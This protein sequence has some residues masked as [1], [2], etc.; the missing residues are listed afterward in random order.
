MRE[1]IET[2]RYFMP[3]TEWLSVADVSEC[4]GV[5]VET[6]RRYI[7]SHGIHLKVKKVHK[8]YLVHNESVA[9]FKQIRELYSDSKNVEEVE[10]ILSS[11]GVPMTVTIENDDDEPMTVSMADELRE[12]K[13]ALI[14]QQQ[15]N[16]DLLEEL[17][18]QKN[19]IENSIEKRDQRLIE[20]LRVIKNE[21]HEA[22][23]EIA[24]RKKKS[25]IF[26]RI[27]NKN[28]GPLFHEKHE[29]D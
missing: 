3:E 9:V 1:R 12:I 23:L 16:Q 18:R 24:P 27:F 11:R 4:T 2:R 28:Q 13:K 19:Y 22:N 10:Q 5:P 15:F 20:S 6:V 29:K 8:R 21:N 26:Q 7:R 14:Q 17:K 25:G